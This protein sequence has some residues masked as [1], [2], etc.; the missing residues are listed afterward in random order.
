[1]KVNCSLALGL[2]SL[3]IADFAAANYGSADGVRRGNAERVRM[4]HR[5]M[6]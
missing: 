5:E 3:N 2:M 6:R 4:I 1:M